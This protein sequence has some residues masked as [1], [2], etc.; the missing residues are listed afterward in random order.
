MNSD[1][2]D[3]DEEEMLRNRK[4]KGLRAFTELDD[5]RREIRSRPSRLCHEFDEE[6]RQLMGACVGEHFNE[7]EQEAACA[8]LEIEEHPRHPLRIVQSR[9]EARAKLQLK[10][11]QELIKQLVANNAVE[12]GEDGK[13]Q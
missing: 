2:S 8:E 13:G 7:V 9:Q 5:N 10:A 12:G 4:R 1:G 11:S 3:G 6:Q